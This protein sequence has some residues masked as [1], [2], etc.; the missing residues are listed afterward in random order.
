[1]QYSSITNTFDYTYNNNDRVIPLYSNKSTIDSNEN[2]ELMLFSSSSQKDEA[3]SDLITYLLSNS[4][5]KNACINLKLESG[6][7]FDVDF[8]EYNQKKLC[9]RSCFVN[10][11][12]FHKKIPHAFLM[13]I[14]LSFKMFY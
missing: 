4:I 2:I 14:F 5:N 6:Q 9:S 10:G 13:I 1:M 12:N 7:N 3:G 11:M 8:F